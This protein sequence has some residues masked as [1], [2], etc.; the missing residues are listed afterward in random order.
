MMGDRHHLRAQGVAWEAPLQVLRSRQSPATR[1]QAIDR[2]R[3][4][5][6]VRHR[7][8]DPPPAPTCRIGV[9]REVRHIT[10]S[11]T[12]EL[13]TPRN[14]L[15]RKSR[16]V[17]DA[18]ESLLF[19]GGDH[20]PVDDQRGSR[21]GMVRVEP[22]NDQRLRHTNPLAVRA[23]ASVRL[24]R[25]MTHRQTSSGQR[26]RGLAKTSDSRFL[27]L[28]GTSP[29]PSPATSIRVEGRQ[30]LPRP[31]SELEGDRRSIPH[32]CA[33]RRRLQPSFA[34]SMRPV[35][36]ASWN[37][38]ILTSPPAA[39]G[40]AI[41]AHPAEEL[42][43]PDAMNSTSSSSPLRRLLAS[44]QRSAQPGAREG[45]PRLRTSRGGMAA[46]PAS[47]WAPPP[48]LAHDATASEA[49]HP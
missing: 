27:R 43:G 45:T 29:L 39:A 37:R 18:P 6:R 15:A 48:L 41:V 24:R 4:R 44:T 46:Q 9:E 33:A 11:Q 12:S 36:T 17:L 21:V 16:P 42:A 10:Q 38:A 22:K 3:R 34:F 19:G 7:P 47:A 23:P 30:R 28:K 25:C 8:Y 2:Q 1:A 35:P 13:K 32:A 40:G 20:P 49:S 5:G 26:L 31:R 14:R